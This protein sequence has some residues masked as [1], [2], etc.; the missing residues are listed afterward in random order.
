MG[1]LSML[2]K[3]LSCPVYGGL[4]TTE[5]PRPERA[6]PGRAETQSFSTGASLIL[7]RFLVRISVTLCLCG[8]FPAIS[9][10]FPV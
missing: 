4:F 5:A 6:E 2:V 10:G 1:N 7:A 3:I 9:Q 8:F